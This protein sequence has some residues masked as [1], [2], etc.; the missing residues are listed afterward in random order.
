[1]EDR[2]LLSGEPFVEPPVIQ[3]QSGVLNARLVEQT[4]TITINGQTATNS[5][6]YNSLF[7]GPTLKFNEGDQLNIDIVNHLT[8]DAGLAFGPTNLHIHGLHVSPQGNGDNLFLEIDPGQENH[9]HDNIPAN[10][11][12]GLYWYHIH[13][14]G[15]VSQQMFEGLSAMM[16]VGRPDGGAEE[17]DVLTQHVL[18]IKNFQTDPTTHLIPPRPTKTPPRASLP[19]TAWSTLS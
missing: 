2:I 15:F 16:I 13:H 14:H 1:M 6:T 9:Y 7:P 3:S 17:L 19:S 5:S 10:H 18:A 4:G 12:E 8:P 11:P